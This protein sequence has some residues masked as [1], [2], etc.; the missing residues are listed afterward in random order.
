MLAQGWDLW[1]EH[2]LELR[3][4]RVLTA[5][6][7]LRWQNG[8]LAKALEKWW[9]EV[10]RARKA[11]KAALMWRNH[12]IGRAW[13]QWTFYLWDVQRLRALSERVVARWKY[14]MLSKSW[15]AWYEHHIQIAMEKEGNAEAERLKK[16]MARMAMKK[17]MNASLSQAWN[18]WRYELRRTRL[19]ER[20]AKRWTHRVWSKAWVAW[21]SMVAEKKRLRAVAKMVVA[22]WK[23]R[24]IAQ[25]WQSWYEDHLQKKRLR[26]LTSRALSKWKVS[27][28][29]TACC[30]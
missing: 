5:K 8:T 22:R 21:E 29:Y 12:V 3:R 20:V 9:H 15:E 10:V 25:A 18:K 2:H 1:Y 19:G 30:G 27:F 24:I 13:R 23:H 7:V 16:M 4:L 11:R 28:V 14:R 6:V 26:H 17:W